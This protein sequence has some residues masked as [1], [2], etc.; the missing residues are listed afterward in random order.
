[1]RLGPVIWASC[2]L[3][4]GGSEYG[5]EMTLDLYH[6]SQSFGRLSA[7][8]PACDVCSFPGFEKSCIILV[9]QLLDFS[10]FSI[11]F[12]SLTKTNSGYNNKNFS[13]WVFVYKQQHFKQRLF[14][15]HLASTGLDLLF[16]S[17][18]A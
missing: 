14:T 11:F 9:T 4:R 16:S 18:L 6:M 17:E 2:V 12:W 7:F 1:M 5:G 13:D 3:Q 8:P 10:V 15:Q